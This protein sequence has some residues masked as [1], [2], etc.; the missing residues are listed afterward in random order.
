MEC[1]INSCVIYMSRSYANFLC[2]VL[3]LVHVLS[4]QDHLQFI[5][6]PTWYFLSLPSS[7][8]LLLSRSSVSNIFLCLSYLTFL[9]TA[10]L[11]NFL[12]TLSFLG[13]W[14]H[15]LLVL[16]SLHRPILILLVSSNILKFVAPQ[17]SSCFPSLFSV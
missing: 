14:F 4:K 12:E 3:V 10:D 5:L 15:T 9:H 7:L 8:K 16:F 2:I 11:S 6:Q 17:D 1:F 13:F